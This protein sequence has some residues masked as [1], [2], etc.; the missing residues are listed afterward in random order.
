MTAAI[1]RSSIPPPK[2]FYLVS[3]L[4]G[5]QS[6]RNWSV[7][8]C[9]TC[10]AVAGHAFVLTIRRP[11]RILVGGLEAPFWSERLTRITGPDNPTPRRHGRRSVPMHDGVYSSIT[12]FAEEVF[13]VVATRFR[14]LSCVPLLFVEC[15]PACRRIWGFLF[16]LLPPVI[17]GRTDSAGRFEIKTEISRPSLVRPLR[18][19]NPCWILAYGTSQVQP[20]PNGRL[21]AR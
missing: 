13:F 21:P 17:A 16:L 5:P 19:Q 8:S 3:T 14:L 9:A 2:E 4:A 1:G 10:S 12:S 11:A 15:L 6:V 18:L 20:P 7:H